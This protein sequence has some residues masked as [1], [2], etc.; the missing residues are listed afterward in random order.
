MIDYEKLKQA[1]TLAQKYQEGNSVDFILTSHIYFNN[2]EPRIQFTYRPCE[3]MTSWINVDDIDDLIAK[4]T[5]LT[6]IDETVYFFQYMFHD[7]VAFDRK[8]LYIKS[9]KMSEVKKLSE[10]DMPNELYSSKND[11][12]DAYAKY[13]SD[14]R[15][16]FTGIE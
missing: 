5:E 1:H 4:L 2:N 14:M 7:G 11:L 8:G 6:Q 16:P 15:D 12:I 13:L 10:F 9:M 3:L